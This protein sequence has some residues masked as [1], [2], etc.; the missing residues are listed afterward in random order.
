MTDCWRPG[1]LKT[2]KIVNSGLCCAPIYM[3]PN[4]EYKTEIKS[5]YAYISGNTGDGCSLCT[6][7]TKSLSFEMQ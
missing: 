7:T 6:A 4:E 2:R 1:L 5:Q 3:R